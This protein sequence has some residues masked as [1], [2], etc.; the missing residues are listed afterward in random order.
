MEC[1]NK[2]MIA[3]GFTDSQSEQMAAKVSCQL[4]T[5]IRKRPKLIADLIRALKDQPGHAVLWIVRG[6]RDGNW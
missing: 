5:I 6:V 1:P 3:G 2:P 4:Q